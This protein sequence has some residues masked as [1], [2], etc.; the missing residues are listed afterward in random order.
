MSVHAMHP[1]RRRLWPAILSGV[2]AVALVAAVVAVLLVRRNETDATAS[3]LMLADG[4]SAG[5]S[6]TG[7]ARTL[8]DAVVKRGLECSARF[9]SAEG[10]HAG[11]FAYHSPSRTTAS[12]TYQYRPDGTVTAINIQVQGTGETGPSIRALTATVGKIL[13]PADMPKVNE[14]FDIWAGGAGGS[15]GELWVQGRGPKTQV[16]G[17]K[18]GAQQL[19]VPVLHLDTTEPGLAKDLTADGYTCTPDNETCQ[20][21]YDGKPGLALK[22]SGPDTG[23]TY[24]VATAATGAT[25]EKAFDQLR[26]AVF[27]H[28]NGAAVAPVQDWVSQHLDGRSHIA[29]VAG[30][31]VDLEVSAGKQIRLTLFNEEV[32]MVMT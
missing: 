13:F 19:K 25:T 24:L 23:L 29:Y 30:W 1:R 3:P 20:G 5:G 31:R 6:L 9:T 8:A 11:C 4:V 17:K 22:F 10:G 16:S 27:S 2:L 26:T 18:R 21:K 32:W 15:W 28:L 12:V 7:E 14:V